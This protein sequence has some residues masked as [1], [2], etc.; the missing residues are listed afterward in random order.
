MHKTSDQVIAAYLTLLEDYAN[1]RLNFDEQRSLKHTD[2]VY[3]AF[4][5]RNI[6]ESAMQMVLTLFGPNCTSSTDQ[7]L[8][9]MGFKSPAPQIDL[10]ARVV[11]LKNAE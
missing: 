8:R 1:T 10:K 7:E 9:N 5:I 6:K 2:F 11:D 3:F 4:Q